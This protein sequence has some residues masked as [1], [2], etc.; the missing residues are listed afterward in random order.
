MIARMIRDTF[1][2]LAAIHNPWPN[3]DEVESDVIYDQLCEDVHRARSEEVE[4]LR[5]GWE[6]GDDDPVLASVRF[7]RSKMLQAEQEL[8]RLLAYAREFTRPRPYTLAELADAAGMSISGIRTAY[9]RDE[10]DY[11]AAAI[12][13]R[14]DVEQSVGKA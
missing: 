10:I 5:A 11:V 2:D 8:R 6:H 14:A 1:A 3:R 13:A 7:A 12:E 9:E 4:S